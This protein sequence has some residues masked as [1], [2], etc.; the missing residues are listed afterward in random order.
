MT[1]DIG[2][3]QIEFTVKACTI[4]DQE[5]KKDGQHLHVVC[6]VCR[7]VGK[8]EVDVDVDCRV[9]SNV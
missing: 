5:W 7:N 9:K 4:I 8:E 3:G 6:N 2:G 1:S